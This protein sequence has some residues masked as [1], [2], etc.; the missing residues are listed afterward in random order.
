MFWTIFPGST[1]HASSSL[2]EDTDSNSTGE[3]VGSNHDILSQSLPGD[4]DANSSSSLSVYATDSFDEQGLE[5]TLQMGCMDALFLLPSVK[6]L[7]KSN[8]EGNKN[9]RVSI[10]SSLESE[11]RS[12]QIN[13]TSKKI[14]LAAKEGLR[15]TIQN[16]CT[17]RNRVEES[18]K[19]KSF[20]NFEH[21]LLL[22]ENTSRE[23]RGFTFESL[24]SLSQESFD[25]DCDSNATEEDM[26]ISPGTH[27]PMHELST[28]ISSS[29]NR[30]SYRYHHQQQRDQ[31]Y[32]QDHQFQRQEHEMHIRV[33]FPYKVIKNRDEDV[34]LAN[35][36]ESLEE[37][38]VIDKRPS[39][40]LAQECNS[41]EDAARAP[42]PPE[43]SIEYE[44]SPEISQLQGLEN[45]QKKNPPLKV[46][47]ERRYVKP[48][49]S[50]FELPSENLKV[51]HFPG[52][53]GKNS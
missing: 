16:A 20:S 35:F 41:F 45:S 37:E 3:S 24:M 1:H 48:S 22:K 21:S 38:P 50:K 44:Y 34:D 9:L 51:I 42:D 17:G 19:G 4:V 10:K 28:S 11:F 8:K 29:F 46:E 40:I 30:K 5:T 33:D 36:L 52:S 31:Q 26:I 18:P 39:Y 14:D 25:D 32:H 47:M 27:F 49:V 13:M 6:N 2:M 23:E 15:Y 53:K 43:D 12:Q 7:R